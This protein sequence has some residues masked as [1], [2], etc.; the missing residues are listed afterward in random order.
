[1]GRAEIFYGGWGYVAHLYDMN[2]CSN[3]WKI[4]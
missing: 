4:L 1:M 2:L 3:Y